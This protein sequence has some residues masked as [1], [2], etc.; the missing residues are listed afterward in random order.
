MTPVA[1]FDHS[2]DPAP[3]GVP[4]TRHAL[5]AWLDECGVDVDVG[6]IALLVASELTTNGVLHDGGAKVT[7]HAE[8]DTHG[9]VLAVDTVDRPEPPPVPLRSVLDPF[10]GGRGLPLVEELTD[11]FEILVDGPRRRTWCR[12]RFPPA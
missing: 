6:H 8:I 5:R 1:A 12:I 3:E 7:L 9:I 10:E 2:F 4:H 11:E